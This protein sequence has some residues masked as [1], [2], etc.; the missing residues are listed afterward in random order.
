MAQP[1]VYKPYKLNEEGHD[2]LS[3]KAAQKLPVAT[4]ANSFESLKNGLFLPNMKPGV[5]TTFFCLQEYKLSRDGSEMTL[6][7]STFFCLQEYKL[8]KMTSLRLRFRLGSL[9]YTDY[10]EQK[11]NALKP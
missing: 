4:Q 6:N 2:I 9:A 7:T 11:L 8:E 1:V 5:P 10:L 3:V